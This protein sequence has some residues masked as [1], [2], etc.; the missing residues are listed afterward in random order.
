MHQADFHQQYFFNVT[1]PSVE[2]PEAGFNR[3]YRLD[4]SRTKFSNGLTS[5]P[6]ISAHSHTRLN[7]DK[8]LHRDLQNNLYRIPSIGWTG[9]Y[10]DS[11]TKEE[12]VRMK[13]KHSREES[14]AMIIRLGDE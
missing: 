5:R 1:W 3:R 9:L 8:R 12:E 13:A 11:R 10:K 14:Q 7:S 6:C 2:G 4:S